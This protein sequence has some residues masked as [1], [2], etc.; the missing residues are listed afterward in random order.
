MRRAWNIIQESVTSDKGYSNLW[1]AIVSAKLAARSGIAR[2]RDRRE[3]YNYIAKAAKKL[4]KLIAE[5]QFL[6]PPGSHL[7]YS[8]DLDVQS[9][10]LLPDD[11]AS[12]LG[13][14][15]WATMDRNERSEWAYHLLSRW[16]TMVELLEQL[17]IRARQRAR[18]KV[19]LVERDR[20]RAPAAIFS[21]YLYNYLRGV[22]PRFTGFAALAAITSI[23]LGVSL[24]G[25][26]VRAMILGASGKT[27]H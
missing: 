18:V 16:P 20:G 6:S 27:T 2:S 12:N 8:G 25:K 21:R 14:K 3:K 13:A 10:E 17:A 11:V 24:D 7:P 9:Y 4:S 19:T 26:A 22:D 15:S 5:Q 23:V 1:T